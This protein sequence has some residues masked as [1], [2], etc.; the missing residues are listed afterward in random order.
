MLYNLKKGDSVLLYG[1]GT[2]GIEYYHKLKDYYKIECFIDRR[3]MTLEEDYPPVLSIDGA[4]KKFPRSCVLVCYHNAREHSE[5][6]ENLYNRGFN[7]IVFL[8][9]DGKYDRKMSEVM[10]EKYCAFEEKE[11]D[12]LM[13][14]PKYNIVKTS[15]TWVIRNGKEYVVSLCPIDIL[16][17]PLDCLNDKERK[18]IDSFS[19]TH[20][21]IAYESAGK[22][23]Y[24]NSVLLM[25]FDYIMQG[26]DNSKLE[27]VIDVR[28]KLS[29]SM[30]LSHNDLIEDR[31]S[32]L[33]FMQEEYNRG[34]LFS[35]YAPIEAKWNKN[36]FFEVFDGQHRTFFAY[37]K[38]LDLIPVRMKCEDYILWKNTLCLSDKEKD[39]ILSTALFRIVN[40]MFA[41]QRYPMVEYGKKSFTFS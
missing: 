41:S 13:N 37:K 34:T 32:T 39:F 10:N 12:L 36:G 25:V 17:T 38:R 35:G 31:R 26:S 29:S 16:F 9:Y 4:M 15:E 8:A 6:A 5:I 33:E 20:K 24:L 11:F 7:K 3:T 28:S 21:Q 27:D 30:I 19:D 1:A 18:V 2:L 22:P 40:P 23:I 14:I